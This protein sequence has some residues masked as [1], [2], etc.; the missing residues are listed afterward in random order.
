MKL[1]ICILSFLLLTSCWPTSISFKDT[2]S[3]PIEWKMFHIQTLAINAPN[4]PLFYGAQ[5][6]EKLKDGIQ[7][8]TRLSLATKLTDAEVQIEGQIL[9]YQVSPIAI[10]NGDNAS[11]NRL[12]VTVQFTINTTKPTEGTT[13]LSSSRF[14]DF[15]ATTNLASVEN[16]LL[17]N[18]T[19]QIVQDLINKLMSNW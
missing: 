14:E 7:N 17:E 12:T 2:G 1:T 19:E 8:N 13:T 5:L 11:K 4:C 15:D 16:Q 6:T 10:Q 9:N 18:I 3:M